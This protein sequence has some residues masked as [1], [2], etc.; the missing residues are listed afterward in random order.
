MKKFII[1]LSVVFLS[2]YVLANSLIIENL[3]N[4]GKDCKKSPTSK[5]LIKISSEIV[6]PFVKDNDFLE[7]NK[8]LL[9]DIL[10]AQA[11]IG[12]LEEANK[13][14]DKLDDD[15]THYGYYTEALINIA[16]HTAI[17]KSP[18]EGV[19]ILEEAINS[20]DE[21]EVLEHRVVD[22]EL[23][24]K[25]NSAKFVINYIK[26]YKNHDDI[27]DKLY[28]GIFSNIEEDY[29][30]LITK[31]NSENNFFIKQLFIANIAELELLENNIQKSF[32]TIEEIVNDE[33]GVPWSVIWLVDNY[34][35]AA[36]YLH[37]N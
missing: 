23:I 11:I 13:T 12:E 2:N 14:L 33:T 5:C 25:I 34:L 29:E 24:Q 4:Y 7:Q 31:K 37:L 17:Y 9:R 26:N 10:K 6:F 27:K 30:T 16:M 15:F 20:I 36:V 21:K 22:M 3:K 28:Y 1:L 19:I 18:D 35:R 8:I 32:D